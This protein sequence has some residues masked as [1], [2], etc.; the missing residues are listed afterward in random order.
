[1]EDLYGDSFR[2]FVDVQGIEEQGEGDRRPGFFRGVSTVCSILFNIVRPDVAVFGQKDGL[3][4][5]FLVF[6]FFFF[7]FF[8]LFLFIFFFFGFVIVLYF[9]IFLFKI[10]FGS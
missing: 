10:V 8:F 2:T 5:L 6:G 7:Y 3:Q 9:C 4:V 1:M